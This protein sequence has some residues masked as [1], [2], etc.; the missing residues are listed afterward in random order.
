MFDRAPA[1]GWARNSHHSHTITM[2]TSVAGAATH[3]VVEQVLGE[4]SVQSVFAL[5]SSGRKKVCILQTLWV[6]AF[7]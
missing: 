5:S 2:L 1:V 6:H 7:C 4:A 3:E